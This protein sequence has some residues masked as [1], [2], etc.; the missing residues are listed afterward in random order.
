V[1]AFVPEMW[2]SAFVLTFFLQVLETSPYMG[3]AAKFF[4]FFINYLHIYLFTHMQSLLFCVASIGG[5][6]KSIGRVA[7]IAHWAIHTQTIAGIVVAVSSLRSHFLCN[8]LVN[9]E[10]VDFELVV[11]KILWISDLS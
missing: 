1:S 9:F 8:E 10:L 4:N 5:S 7:G 11:C 6:V 3:G 2:L